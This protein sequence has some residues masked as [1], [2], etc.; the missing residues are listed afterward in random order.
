QLEKSVQKTTF[1]AIERGLVQSA[2][3]C[4]EGGLAVSLAES[5]ISNPVKKLGAVINLTSRNI[6]TDA[7]LFGETQS[8]IVVSVKA[9][10]L[11]K[12]LQTA[13]KNK[14]PVSIIGEVTGNKLIINSLINI[15]V[16]DLYKA[17]CNV[18]ENYLKD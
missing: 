14:A 16:N 11:K 15:S 17:W 13:R 5:C 7:L 8:R 6:R 12:V 18:I 10:N 1:Q 3:D 9:K 4:S 2:H